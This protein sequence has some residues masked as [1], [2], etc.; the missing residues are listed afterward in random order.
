HPASCLCFAN[1]SAPE[2]RPG[3]RSHFADGG[4]A[5]S[6]G[7]ASLLLLGVSLFPGERGC[8]RSGQHIEPLRK[9][10]RGAPG[11]TVDLSVPFLVS[12]SCRENCARPSRRPGFGR[13]EEHTS[14]LQSPDHLVCRLLLEKQ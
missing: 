4:K 5:F 8:C 6:E 9:L 13:S 7:M 14:E 11:A 3:C 12:D 1:L 10:D 2:H